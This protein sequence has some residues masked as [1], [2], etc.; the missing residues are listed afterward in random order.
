MAFKLDIQGGG[1]VL[2]VK[3]IQ[4]P[5][6]TVEF[7][8]LEICKIRSGKHLSGATWMEL[9]LPAVHGNGLD[10][11]VWSFQALQLSDVLSVFPKCKAMGI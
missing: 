11:A 2:Q 1:N 5:G 4:F 3:P 9:I 10:D 8:R 7:L 6:K